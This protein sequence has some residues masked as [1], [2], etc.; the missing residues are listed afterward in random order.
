MNYGEF[1]IAW[2]LFLP[3]LSLLNA[4]T[5]L[6]G[7]PRLC[8]WRWGYGKA[9]L[10]WRPTGKGC[11]CLSLAPTSSLVPHPVPVPSLP[12]APYHHRLLLLTH[13][14]LLAPH[15]LTRMFSAPPT[16]TY[17][18]FSFSR[19]SVFLFSLHLRHFEFSFLI[20]LSTGREYVGTQNMI[21]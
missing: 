13:P 20:L 11:C 19:C 3:T 2:V 8:D 9:V 17:K 5:V 18:H 12:S 4:K 21:K 6:M 1:Y 7:L 14:A 15:K 16:A 10:W